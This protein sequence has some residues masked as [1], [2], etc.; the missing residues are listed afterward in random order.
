MK[1]CTRCGC[2]KGEEGYYRDSRR[3]DGRQSACKECV[4]ASEY[5]RVRLKG[6][7]GGGGGGGGVGAGMKRGE[8][9][10]VI[11]EAMGLLLRGL[12]LGVDMEWRAAARE[13]LEGW[14]GKG[15][16]GGSGVSGEGKGWGV[17]DGI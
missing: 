12:R 6:G 10:R 3:I 8:L 11:E 17:K 14:V 4:I 9:V 13:W 16:V 15:C 7:G 5:W 2:M 1:R